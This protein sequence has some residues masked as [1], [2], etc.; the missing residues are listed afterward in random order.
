M[1]RDRATALQ[2]GQQNETMSQ[3]KIEIVLATGVES[4][5]HSFI[6]YCL[7][8]I[9]DTKDTIVNKYILWRSVRQIYVVFAF[10]L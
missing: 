1:G 2:A 7:A 9:L 4:F 10:Y 3:K 5:M 8:T 6:E